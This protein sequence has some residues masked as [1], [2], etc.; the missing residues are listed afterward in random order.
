MTLLP[1]KYLE[2]RNISDSGTEWSSI[3]VSYLILLHFLLLEADPIPELFQFIANHD[4]HQ[5]I[6]QKMPAILLWNTG[7]H[8]LAFLSVSTITCL[9][10]LDWSLFMWTS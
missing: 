8:I 2:T 5:V 6:K 7:L 3:V 9:D 4:I 10:E 1:R